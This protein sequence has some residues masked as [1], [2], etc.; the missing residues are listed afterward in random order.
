MNFCQL[1]VQPGDLPSTFVNF[2]C[3]L[4]TFCQLPSTIC[5]ARRLSV[6]FL[7]GLRPSI[8]FCQLY[9]PPGDFCKLPSSFRVTGSLFVNF[10]KL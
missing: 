6:K 2:P 3:G 10:L 4:E 9:V 8:N 5:A 1:L 7:C